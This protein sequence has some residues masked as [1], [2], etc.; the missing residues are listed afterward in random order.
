MIH[1]ARSVRA[2]YSAALRARLGS[3]RR[4]MKS[5]SSRAGIIVFRRIADDVEVIAFLDPLHAPA[6]FLA[7]KRLGEFLRLDIAKQII[8][9]RI[10][11]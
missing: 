8:F 10:E 7:R 2:A 9:V 1:P 6:T 11:D 4:A 3:V 5:S